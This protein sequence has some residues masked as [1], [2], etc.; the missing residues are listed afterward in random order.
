MTDYRLQLYKIANVCAMHLYLAISPD[1]LS[2]FNALLTGSCIYME[3][4]KMLLNVKDN[5]PYTNV[6]TSLFRVDCWS[7]VQII[8]MLIRPVQALKSKKDNVFCSICLVVKIYFH[9]VGHPVT[10]L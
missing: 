10:A 5:L 7:I 4:F 1:V 2:I 9:W 8:Q 6:L 3:G